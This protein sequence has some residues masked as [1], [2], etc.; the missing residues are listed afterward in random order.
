MNRVREYSLEE[1]IRTATINGLRKTFIQLRGDVGKP[2]GFPP[3]SFFQRLSIEQLQLVENAIYRSRIQL[4]VE[5][6]EFFKEFD[7]GTSLENDEIVGWALI[8]PQHVQYFAR[9]REDRGSP[10]LFD[11]MRTRR[12]AAGNPPIVRVKSGIF[13]TQLARTVEGTT[14]EPEDAAEA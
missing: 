3:E 6:D 7:S 12:M 1:A 14:I 5:K 8:A 13:L 9:L 10:T 2:E 11:Q 4:K